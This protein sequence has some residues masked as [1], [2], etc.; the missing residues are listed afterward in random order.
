[1]AAQF[2]SILRRAALALALALSPP[3]AGAAAD[4][5]FAP[6]LYVNGSAITAYE[7]EQRAAFLGLLRTPGDLQKIAR[8]GL[9]DDRLHA[10]AAATLEVELADEA[11]TAGMEEFAKRAN[12]SV[13]EFVA[14]IDKAGIDPET[15]RDFVRSGL[16]W[17]EAVQR[18]YRP[19]ISVT[20]R[21]VEEALSE[22]TRKGEVRLLVNELVVPYAPDRQEDAKAFMTELR[23]TLSNQDEFEAAAKKYSRSAT[24]AEGGRLDWIPLSNLPGPLASSVL[25]LGAGSISDVLSVP[26]AYVLFYIRGISDGATAASSDQELDW[27]EFLVPKGPELGAALASVANR[28]DSCD[29]L[30]TVAKDL[31]ADRLKRTKARLGQVPRDVAARLATMDPGDTDTALSRGGWQ[32]FLMLCTRTPVAGEGVPDIDQMS[33]TLLG[34]KLQNAAETWQRELRAMA[35]IREP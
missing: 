17:R 5:P 30:Y 1:M 24:A 27:A 8:E 23:A 18:K 10:Q 25:T 6:V 31:P 28:V 19:L 13:E 33:N 12:L 14:E 26:G 29:D 11:I 7:V 4:N 16:L 34:R 21:E 35:V 15:F 3:V 32:V 20:L 9:I 2:L 22:A